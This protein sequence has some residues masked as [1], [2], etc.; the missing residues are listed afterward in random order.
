[1]FI[2]LILI[3]TLNKT[4]FLC[5]LKIIT[6]NLPIY[7]VA[8]WILTKPKVNISLTADVKCFNC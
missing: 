3:T 6:S 1:M 7:V 4:T 2:I 8:S 5:K